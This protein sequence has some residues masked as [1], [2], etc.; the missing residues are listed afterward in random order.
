ML[1]DVLCV[2][3]DLWIWIYCS[4]THDGGCSRVAECTVC[5]GYI[6]NILIN[7]DISTKLKRTKLKL[8]LIRPSDL[9]VGLP[10]YC[11]AVVSDYCDRLVDW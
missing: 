3:I 1:L 2:V 4:R 7:F 10:N 9:G 8:K 6:R 5:H 11:R